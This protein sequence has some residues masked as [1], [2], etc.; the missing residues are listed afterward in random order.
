MMYRVDEHTR[1]DMNE[2]SEGLVP[3]T[4]SALK[5]MIGG[6]HYK[7]G[8]IQPIEFIVANDLDYIQGNIVKY[9]TRYKLKG[10]PVKDLEKIIH[11]AELAIE[12]ETF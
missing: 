6:N 11:Y 8:A 2:S 12:L 4:N 7:E 1:K 10:T 5:R 3:L 9:A